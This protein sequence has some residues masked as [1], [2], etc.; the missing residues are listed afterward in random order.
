KQYRVI[1]Q[2]A[3]DGV[4]PLKISPLREIAAGISSTVWPVRI[5]QWPGNRGRHL[6]ISESSDKIR[7]VADPCMGRNVAAQGQR[8]GRAAG[9]HRPIFSDPPGGRSAIGVDHN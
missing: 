4:V 7:P 2:T 9:G 3:E 6:G 8:R 5:Y 1:G